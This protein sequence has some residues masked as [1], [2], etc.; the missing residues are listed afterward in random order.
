MEVEVTRVGGVLP[1]YR[2]VSLRGVL[3]VVIIITTVY[4]EKGIDNGKISRAVEVRIRMKNIE[5]L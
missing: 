5:K 4:E 1:L 2:K 3:L